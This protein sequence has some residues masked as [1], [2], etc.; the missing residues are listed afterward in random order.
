MHVC[1]SGNKPSNVV[2]EKSDTEDGLV[3][4]VDFIGVSGVEGLKYLEE[5]TFESVFN[6]EL[7]VEERLSSCLSFSDSD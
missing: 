3:E 2:F 5:S 4:V 6:D 7:P 1:S